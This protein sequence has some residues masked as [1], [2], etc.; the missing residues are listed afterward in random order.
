MTNSDKKKAKQQS[1]EHRIE[2]WNIRTMR[3][4]LTDDLD[5]I[6]DFWKTTIID[7]E[8]KKLN[9]D[10]VALQ[11]TRLPE[12]GSL[13]EE[14]YTFFWH[15]KGLDETHEHGVGFAVRNTLLTMM[16]S[17]AHLAKA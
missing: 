11:E 5:N 4:G 14:N 15:G 2:T 16:R 17:L 13:K 10:I 12:T 1:A 3:K 8:L 7:M 9:V 6:Q